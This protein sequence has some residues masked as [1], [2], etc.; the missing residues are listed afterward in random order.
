[1]KS[2]HS[3]S[4]TPVQKFVAG[5]TIE[6]FNRVKKEA[7]RLLELAPDSP[8]SVDS[9]HDFRVSVRRLRTVLQ[10]FQD[11]FPSK[12]VKVARKSLRRAFRLAGEVRN[13]DITIELLKESMLD[14]AEGISNSLAAAR[15]E[16]QQVLM[17]NVQDWVS[18][19]FLVLESGVKSS[20]KYQDDTPAATASAK[21]LSQHT[22]HFFETGRHVF[23]HGDAEDLHQ[24]R[25]AAKQFRYLIEVFAPVYG[26]RLE[27]KLE[28]LK[29]LQ[30]YLGKLNDLVTAQ[31]LMAKEK[32]HRKVMN[33]LKHREEK[34]RHELTEY[35]KK[36]MD[37]EKN[38]K[39]WVQFFLQPGKQVQNQKLMLKSQ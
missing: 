20:E 19:D 24:F 38:Q 35:W 10:S 6:R 4:N 36:G 27:K 39:A 18:T 23:A 2:V 30:R 33:W 14:E 9:V 1:M 26:A 25:I 21:L 31:A 22:D 34:V 11:Y 28:S 37:L 32:H 29:E 17:E 5:Q 13:R 3:V 12:A 16:H 15:L 7:Q 8:E